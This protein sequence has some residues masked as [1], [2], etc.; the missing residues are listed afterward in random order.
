MVID[1][2]EEIVKRTPGGVPNKQGV[3]KNN[4]VLG[5]QVPVEV[6]ELNWKQIAADVERHYLAGDSILVLTRSNSV[7]DEARDELEELLDRA[8][9]EKRSSQI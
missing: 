5:H 1:A 8:R 2:A 3:A 6:R 7:K 4:S 9:M